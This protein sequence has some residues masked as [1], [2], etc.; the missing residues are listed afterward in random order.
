MYVWN[1][2]E[3]IDLLDQGPIR[4]KL[5]FTN[6]ELMQFTRDM[7]TADTCHC[8]TG[9]KSC[10]FISELEWT[11]RLHWWDKDGRIAVWD[12]GNHKFTN[13]LANE[14]DKVIG[15]SEDLTRSTCCSKEK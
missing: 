3:I 4:L 9:H 12:I 10:G 15:H 2:E 14:I 5:K 8:D 1:D 7:G 6:G 11:D 13:I